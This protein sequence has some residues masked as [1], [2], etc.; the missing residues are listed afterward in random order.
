MNY[1]QATGKNIGRDRDRMATAGLTFR[2]QDGYVVMAG[3]RNPERWRELWKLVGRPELSE[4]PRY[5][6]Q[7]TDG[8]FYAN[9][10]LPALEEWSTQRP[11]WEVAGKL[12]EIGFS[13]GTAQTIAD[14]A[15]CPHLE[16]RDMF[17][18]TDDTLG[19]RFR[20]L[21]TP[22]RLTD[23]VASGQGTP[24]KLGEHNRE[25][26]CTLGGL[27]VE[28]LRELEAEGMV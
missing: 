2:A 11:K 1:F 19:G 15:Q 9:N 21:R 13:M 23:C 16:A 18:D 4:D 14:L 3:V 12:T 17:V 27:T 28:E 22:V 10:I 8:D 5:L 25:L 7:G 26:L 6:S 20:S 24:P